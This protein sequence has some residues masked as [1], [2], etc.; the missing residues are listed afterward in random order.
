ME[1]F[2]RDVTNAYA[3]MPTGAFSICCPRDCVSRHNGGTSG[4]LLM[5]RDAV[6]RT[7]N[8]ERTGQH[9]WVKECK[10]ESRAITQTNRISRRLEQQCPLASLACLRVYASSV[11]FSMHASFS[12]KMPPTYYKAFRR[13]E[14]LYQTQVNNPAIG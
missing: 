12:V 13:V 5:P 11:S 2:L 3:F 4:A 9:K 6:S 7:A 1:R 14:T 10:R 8:V